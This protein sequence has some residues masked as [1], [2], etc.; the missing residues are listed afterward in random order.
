MYDFRFREPYSNGFDRGLEVYKVW[1]SFTHRYTHGRLSYASDKL[2]AVAG[3][4]AEVQGHLGDSDEYLAGLWKA[5]PREELLWDVRGD[6]KPNVPE[7]YRA[8]SWSWARIGKVFSFLVTG[9]FSHRIKLALTW[10]PW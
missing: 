2:V 8:P 9:F 7:V 1:N 10:L 5:F 6:W 3:L 4:A